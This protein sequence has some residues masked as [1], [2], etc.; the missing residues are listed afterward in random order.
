MKKDP[1]IKIYVILIIVILIAIGLVVWLKLSHVDNDNKNNDKNSNINSSLYNSWNK[2]E[3]FLYRDGEL[4]NEFTEDGSSY[5]IINPD[6]IKICDN[7][8]NSSDGQVV[9]LC[10]EY[11]YT[12]NS[13]AITI[14]NY[15]FYN[16]DVTY[17]YQISED[18]NTLTLQTTSS[19]TNYEIDHYTKSLG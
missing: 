10:E 7:Y 16:E 2:T 15:S 9:S 17:T 12:V 11:S 18:G 4:E 14:H 3:R 19:D 8:E 5:M 6:S 13:D 1:K